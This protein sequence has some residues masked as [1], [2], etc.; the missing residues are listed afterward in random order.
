MN[1][2]SVRL[3]EVNP[4]APMDLAMLF[5]LLAEREPWQAISHREM[6][7][8]EQHVAFV[9]SEPYKAWYMIHCDGEIVGSTYF[10]HAN[11]IGIFIFKKYKGRHIA[12]AAIMLLQSKHEG[13]YYA[14]I[15]PENKASILFFEKLGFEPLQVTYVQ[16]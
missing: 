5:H 12:K 3:M 11:E 16:E 8:W 13:P 14:N 4:H 15:N 10:S 6:P 1:I 2:Q 7:T 9:R